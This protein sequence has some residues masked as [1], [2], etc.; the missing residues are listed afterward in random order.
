MIGP[1]VAGEAERHVLQLGIALFLGF[2]DDG[3]HDLLS[4]RAVFQA[5]VLPAVGIRGVRF[6]EMDQ[7]TLQISSGTP[8]NRG[9]GVSE[10]PLLA[11]PLSSTGTNPRVAC[12]RRCVR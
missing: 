4:S 8:A 1:A 11:L 6:V 5:S 12:N 9:R 10:Q 2:R 7:L 3:L